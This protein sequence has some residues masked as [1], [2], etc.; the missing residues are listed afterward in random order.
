MGPSL[1]TLKTEIWLPRRPLIGILAGGVAVSFELRN[2]SKCPLV[3]TD[4]GIEWGRR[5][6]ARAETRFPAPRWVRG[7]GD[8]ELM[9]FPFTAAPRSN[10]RLFV[11]LT[12][13]CP[14]HLIA[15]CF[16]SRVFVTSETGKR[17]RARCGDVRNA[18]RA[19]TQYW[20]ETLSRIE[21]GRLHPSLK[22]SA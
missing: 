8:S 22:H 1:R 13:D 7:R 3:I 6:T 12:G 20:V 2:R 10:Y 9:A 16:S 11:R 5:F 4:F 14:E 15:A 19:W 18:C 21:E 17:I